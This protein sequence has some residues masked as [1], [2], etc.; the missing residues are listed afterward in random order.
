[1]GIAGY[2]VS[3]FPDCRTCTRFSSTVWTLI[4]F[5]Y[6]FWAR[7]ANSLMLF[8][9]FSADAVHLRWVWIDP[10]WASLALAVLWAWPCLVAFFPGGTDFSTFVKPTS[11]QWL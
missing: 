6:N 2:G 10:K 5:N 4:N 7:N 11:A 1:M 9:C 3:A 8:E